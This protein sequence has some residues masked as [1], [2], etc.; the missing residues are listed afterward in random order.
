MMYIEGGYVTILEGGRMY[1][2]LSLLE[3]GRMCTC[4]LL[5]WREGGCVCYRTG[6]RKGGC[7]CSRTGGR[8]DV[9]MYKLEGVCIILLIKRINYYYF[10]TDSDF[11][12]YNCNISH[13]TIIN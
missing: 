6:R 3:G 7:V 2:Y 12:V 10:Y 13:V 5:Y 9:Y 8:E 4:M 1:M 11:C